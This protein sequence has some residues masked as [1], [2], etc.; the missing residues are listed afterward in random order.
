M[1]KVVFIIGAPRSGTNMLRDSLS[2]HPGIVTWQCD[3]INDVWHQGNSYDHDELT[4]DSMDDKTKSGIK[5]F[6]E[7]FSKNN[8]GKIVLEKTCANS[9]RVELLLSLFPNAVF[10]Y[11][12]RNGY[13]CI[14]STEKRWYGKTSFSY[15]W[16]KVIV[17]PLRLQL[18]IIFKRVIELFLS[19]LKLN[20]KLW[21]PR[22]K[23]IKTDL[24]E[25][26]LTQVIE[27]QW[28]A[29]VN[30]SLLSLESTRGNRVILKYEEFTEDGHN[31]LKEILEKLDLHYD[32]QIIRE[33]FKDVRINNKTNEL[34]SS[35]P[36]VDKLNRI[37]SKL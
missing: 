26:S 9:L 23:G 2:K 14:A 8:P 32:D 36:G 25:L 34:F 4:E 30:S 12:F 37:V 22:Y 28:M 19:K 20:K 6:F 10:I 7:K 17:L 33:M 31:K 15:L 3:E 1:N 18:R 21:G 11:I 27:R 24:A 29:C 35:S 16:R 5:E 13:D